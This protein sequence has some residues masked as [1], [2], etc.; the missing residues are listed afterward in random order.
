MLLHSGEL[1]FDDVADPGL[2]PVDVI[3]SPYAIHVGYIKAMLEVGAT[4]G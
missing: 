2:K 1:L 3:H 4:T